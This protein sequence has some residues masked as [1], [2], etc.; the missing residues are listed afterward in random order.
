MVKGRRFNA[1]DL[2][3]LVGELDHEV[4]VQLEHTLNV[5][6]V[7]QVLTQQRIVFIL[8]RGYA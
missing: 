7:P 4:L 1:Y 2:L 8:A 3:V 5:H 6:D